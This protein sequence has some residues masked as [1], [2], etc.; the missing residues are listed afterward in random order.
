MIGKKYVHNWPK[1]I[2]HYEINSQKIIKNALLLKI[3]KLQL[4]D[5]K[6]I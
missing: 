3:L 2:G 6:F 1:L 5:G 4:F